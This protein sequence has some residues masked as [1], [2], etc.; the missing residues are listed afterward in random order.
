VLCL[1]SRSILWVI[2]SLQLGFVSRKRFFPRGF[3]S[4]LSQ[5][6]FVGSVR[7]SIV[8]R[9]SCTTIFDLLPVN[10]V[11]FDNCANVNTAPARPPIRGA[12]L[13]LGSI[14]CPI[15][16][17]QY[18]ITQRHVHRE[19]NFR[20]IR[21][22]RRLVLQKIEDRCGIYSMPIEE[23][24]AQCRDYYKTAHLV[25]VIVPPQRVAYT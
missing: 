20:E 21:D 1:K 12:M 4:Y 14:P 11:Y 10:R 22:R 6:T 13:I 19:H 15:A 23:F 2:T 8:K 7:P 16:V 25:D 5:R 24:Q 3:S 17:T 9:T 18:G